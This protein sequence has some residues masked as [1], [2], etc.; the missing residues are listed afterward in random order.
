MLL[1]CSGGQPTPL[2]SLQLLEIQTG[3]GSMGRSFGAMQRGVHAVIV[4]TAGFVDLNLAFCLLPA[5]PA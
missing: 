1:L 4:G 5:L 3:Q 2:C